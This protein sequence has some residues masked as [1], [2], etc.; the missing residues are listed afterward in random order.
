MFHVMVCPLTVPP[1]ETLEAV[2]PVGTF[3]Q[4]LAPVGTKS[5]DLAALAAFA[6]D[7]R[8]TIVPEERHDDG[9]TAAHLVAFGARLEGRQARLA[10]LRKPRHVRRVV[11]VGDL[12]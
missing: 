5:G 4:I 9:A 7:D 2:Q 10:N 1:A 3:S 8:D 12:R 6:V 11:H